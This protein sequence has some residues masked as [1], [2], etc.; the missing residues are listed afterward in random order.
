LE[1]S[2]C[3]S[4][5]AS[6]GRAGE[7]LAVAEILCDHET[8]TLALKPH[9]A[10]WAGKTSVSRK[11]EFIC[12]DAACAVPG[13]GWWAPGR[14]TLVVFGAGLAVPRRRIPDIVIGALEAEFTLPVHEQVAQRATA[15]GA[16]LQL[17]LHAGFALGADGAGAGADSLPAGVGIQSAGRLTVP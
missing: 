5:P 11:I 9:G 3:F 17:V 16:Y 8:D 10:S 13:R 14:F 1:S 2:T 7:T 6:L 4:V 15:V 12:A